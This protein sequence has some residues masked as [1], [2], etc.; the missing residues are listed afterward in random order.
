[1]LQAPF[2]TGPLSLEVANLSK[3]LGCE[4]PPLSFQ[5]PSGK[6][7]HLIPNC[8]FLKNAGDSNQIDTVSSGNVCGIISSNVIW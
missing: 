8:I 6:V 1:M 4:S 2:G 3:V 7:G 5:C